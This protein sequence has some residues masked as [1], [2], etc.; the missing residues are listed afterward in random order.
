MAKEP[1]QDN[2]FEKLK[3]MEY[4]ANSAIAAFTKMGLEEVKWIS[5]GIPSFDA[6]TMIPR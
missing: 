2:P 4:D 3:D 5:T 1:D 6:L